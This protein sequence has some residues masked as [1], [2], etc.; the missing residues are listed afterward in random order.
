MRFR[1]GRIPS[2][3]EIVGWIMDGLSDDSVNDIP[4][5]H[6][7]LIVRQYFRTLGPLDPSAPSYAISPSQPTSL[8]Y[9][10]PLNCNY[11][12]PR[13]T[14]LHPLCIKISRPPPK[15]PSILPGRLLLLFRA[16]HYFT[17]FLGTHPILSFYD[18]YLL[19]RYRC[20]MFLLCI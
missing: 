3:R 20:I 18:C 5:F 13:T 16:I 10:S 2:R 17:R 9:K 7:M 12:R 15:S 1:R 4:S 19:T 6:D 8:A 11:S 14:I